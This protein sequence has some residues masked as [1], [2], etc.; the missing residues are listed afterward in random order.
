MRHGPVLMYACLLQDITYLTLTSPHLA[1][2]PAKMSGRHESLIY[3]TAEL[4]HIRNLHIL[5]GE[6][7]TRVTFCEIVE[8]ELYLLCDCV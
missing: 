3:F 1:Y 7:I 4:L 5:H 6:K 8:A 2:L